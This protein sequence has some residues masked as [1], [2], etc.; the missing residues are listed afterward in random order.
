MFGEYTLIEKLYDVFDSKESGNPWMSISVSEFFSP[1]QRHPSL[2]AVPIPLG[3]DV[4]KGTMRP[5]I[6]IP[7]NARKESLEYTTNCF[8]LNLSCLVQNEQYFKRKPWKLGSDNMNFEQTISP[9]F[10]ADDVDIFAE[11]G[12]PS[13]QPTQA[14]NPL[15][16]ILLEEETPTEVDPQL[17]AG[18]LQVLAQHSIRQ[19]ST[20]PKNV[21][22]EHAE[23][24]DLNSARVTLIDDEYRLSLLVELQGNQHIRPC[25]RAQHDSGQINL[26]EEPDI[27]SKWKPLYDLL[28]NAFKQA[29][30]SLKTSTQFL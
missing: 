28:E 16:S 4:A 20:D 17:V 25:V 9:D 19:H 10:D 6:T 23:N 7:I 3:A 2:A 18:L 26:V 22:P 5:R 27:P 11:L 21:M 13:V 30:L 14:S 29:I 1:W 8:H 12:S 15:H 24:V